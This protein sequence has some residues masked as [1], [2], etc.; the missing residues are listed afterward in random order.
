MTKRENESVLIG[1]IE[2][3]EIRIVDYDPNWPAQCQTHANK[4]AEALDDGL[5]RIEHIGSTVRLRY[6]GLNKDQT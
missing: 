1:G 3:V 2:K 4:I 6:A 5:L